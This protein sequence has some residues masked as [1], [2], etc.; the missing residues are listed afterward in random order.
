MGQ[1]YFPIHINHP[2]SHKKKIAFFW[3]LTQEISLSLPL[4]LP[5]SP[6]P[7]AAAMGLRELGWV[8]DSCWG[9]CQALAGAARPA[10]RLPVPR[11]IL[12]MELS[13]SHVLTNWADLDRQNSLLARGQA[14]V[15]HAQAACPQT[16][17]WQ[18]GASCLMHLS[19]VCQG[20]PAEGSGDRIR[21]LVASCL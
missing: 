2:D 16:W 12:L 5:T 15:L 1:Q 20:S 6:P 13:R 21:P 14:A 9:R 7:R 4:I 17:R 3:K 19:G 8:L 10:L 11:M 18:W